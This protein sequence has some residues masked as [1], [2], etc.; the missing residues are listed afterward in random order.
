MGYIA[1]IAK[2]A[3]VRRKLSRGTLGAAGCAL[4]VSIRAQSA[5][6]AR[7]S[8]KEKVTTY[9]KFEVTMDVNR[10]I[11]CLVLTSE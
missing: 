11:F 9:S 8:L 5:E 1:I 2:G 3:V 7:P 6:C 10:N 4:F